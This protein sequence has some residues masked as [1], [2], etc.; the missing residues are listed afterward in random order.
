M[1][2]AE[3]QSTAQV[4]LIMSSYDA[5]RGAGEGRAFEPSL[6]N[7]S[8]T[9]SAGSNGQPMPRGPGR[10]LHRC[11]YGLRRCWHNILFESTWLFLFILGV[12]S[13]FLAWCQDELVQFLAILRGHLV[14]S[15]ESLILKTLLY[16]LFMLLLVIL[17]IVLTRTV[18]PMAV[19][20]G[21]PQMK[22]ILSGQCCHHAPNALDAAQPPQLP[23]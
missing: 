14:G 13:A 19:G 17:A 12:T 21:I 6:G 2:K 8:T 3:D 11:M 5:P 20:S 7:H 10:C 1:I 22:S 15:V 16:T 18:G 23:R 9:V 4:P